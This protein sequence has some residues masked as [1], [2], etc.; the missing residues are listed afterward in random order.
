MAAMTGDTL[1]LL[2]VIKRSENGRPA[3]II[4]GLK[5]LGKRGVSGHYYGT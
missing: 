1:G 2:L 5:R 4:M 3:G